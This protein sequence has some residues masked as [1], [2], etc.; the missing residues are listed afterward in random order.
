MCRAMVKVS[1]KV[2]R[3]YWGLTGTVSDERITKGSR[4]DR[5]GDPQEIEIE[6]E[7][8]IVFED[9]DEFKKRCIARG[10]TGLTHSLQLKVSQLTFLQ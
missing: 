9:N 8:R 5:W 2:C 4:R 3:D 1:D 6:P 7:C 10:P